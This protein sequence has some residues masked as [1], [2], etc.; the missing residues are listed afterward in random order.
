MGST[1]TFEVRG[2]RSELALFT[3]FYLSSIA[4]RAPRVLRAARWP[5]ITNYD[6]RWSWIVGSVVPKF[7]RLD[8]DMRLVDASLRRIFADGRTYS[9]LPCV[10]PSD[11]LTDPASVVAGLCCPNAQTYQD[12]AA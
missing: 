12:L 4:S 3:S 8:A 7:R 11:A 10:V 6:D 1:T 2:V 9:S 5:R